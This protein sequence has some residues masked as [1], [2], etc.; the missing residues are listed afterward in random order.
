MSAEIIAKAETADG[1]GLCLWSD[2]HLTQ[3]LGIYIP[4][5]GKPRNV[6]AALRAGRMVLGDAS[7]YAMSEILDLYRCAKKADTPGDMRSRYARL[8]ST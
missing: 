1:K 8:R 6:E 7:L 3:I 4:G 5:V 2:G